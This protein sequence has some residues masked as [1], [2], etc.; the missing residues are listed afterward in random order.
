M[1]GSGGRQ[2]SDPR[3]RAALL[4][5]ASNATLIVLKV[6]AGTLTGSVAVLTEAVHSGVDLVAS[7]IAYASISKAGEPADESHSY[8]HEKLENVAAA[9]EG[10]LILSGSAVI[11]YAAVRRLLGHG[12]T[13]NVGI[14]IVVVSLSV[15]VNLVV[16]HV[17]ARTAARTGSPALEGDAVHLRTDAVSSAA[18][19]V[20]LVLVGVTGRQ[21][22]DPVVALIVAAA[23]ARTGVRLLMRSGQVLVDQ[24]LPAD[25]LQTIAAVIEPFA[26]AGVVGYHQLRTRRAGTQRHVDVHVQFRSGTTLEEAHRTAHRLTDAIASALG[27]ADVLIHIEPEDRVRPGETLAEVRPSGSEPGGISAEMNETRDDPR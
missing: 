4:P 16:A 6:I 14:G 3:R 8:G 26:A 25:E 2:S 18:V 10:I 11:A 19:I 20:A 13:H 24:A 12:Q 21:W 5:V 23:I 1:P 22:I 17:I 15:G 7:V 27:G 9:V